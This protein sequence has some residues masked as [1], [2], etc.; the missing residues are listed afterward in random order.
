MKL[1]IFISA[2]AII[3]AFLLWLFRPGPLRRRLGIEPWKEPD[4]Y[5]IN[6]T[7]IEVLRR[8]SYIGPAIR[9]A[10]S[11]QTPLS[12]NNPEQASKKAA[13]GFDY[14]RTPYGAKVICRSGVALSANIN[15]TLA[16]L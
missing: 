2:L 13:E 15:E 8:D 7:D 12:L 6:G 5:Y 1:T 16:P 10:E 11:R 14:F 3:V 4:P 9:T